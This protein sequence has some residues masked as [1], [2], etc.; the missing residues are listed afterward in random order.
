[1]LPACAG[2]LLLLPQKLVQPLSVLIFRERERGRERE[3]ETERVRGR[4]GRGERE[5]HTER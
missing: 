2:L 4:E 5:T 3:K 1:M